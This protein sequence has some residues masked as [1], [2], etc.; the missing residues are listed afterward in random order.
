MQKANEST[1]HPDSE[2][3]TDSHYDPSAETLAERIAAL[4]DIIPPSTRAWIS[5][6]ASTIRKFTTGAVFLSGR[7]AWH[8]AT[9][10]LLVG[11]PFA[12]ANF[13][14]QQAI[15]MEQ[16]QRMREM[17][18]DMLTVGGGEK[19]GR[20]TAEQVGAALGGGGGGGARPAL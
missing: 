13:E 8:L 16:E 9:S 4:R 1:S 12:L 3:S 15:A 17:G 6:R 18:Q 20:S 19:E 14:E 2:I 11:V 10:A 7:V 5:G